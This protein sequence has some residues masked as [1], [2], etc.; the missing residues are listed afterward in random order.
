VARRRSF[1]G[2]ALPPTDSIARNMVNQS[3]TFGLHTAGCMTD[4]SIIRRVPKAAEFLTLITAAQRLRR[5]LFRRREDHANNE[6]DGESE[7]IRSWQMVIRAADRFRLADVPIWHLEKGA[8]TLAPE[9]GF[10]AG[11][12]PPVVGFEDD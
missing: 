2:M 12:L 3:S 11:S 8:P 6:L 5:Q 4:R 7:T 9:H 10:F 1:L